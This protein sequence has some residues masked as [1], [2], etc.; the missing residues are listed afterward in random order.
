M[1]PETC[2]QYRFGASRGPFPRCLR[3]STGRVGCCAK[4]HDALAR[5]TWQAAVDD[6]DGQ[7]RSLVETLRAV[8]VTDPNE[9]VRLTSKR[10]SFHTHLEA[11]DCLLR[12]EVCR[13][14][15]GGRE[16][17]KRHRRRLDRDPIHV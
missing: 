4:Q 12:E 2:A 3:A 9:C 8:G 1:S 14:M 15:E 17:F 7:Y 6:A 10:Q 5:S 13:V 11:L 16:E